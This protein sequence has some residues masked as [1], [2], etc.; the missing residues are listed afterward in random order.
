MGLHMIGLGLQNAFELGDGVGGLAVFGQHAPEVV[1][2]TNEV[3][4]QFEAALNSL[5]A[6]ALR[7][8]RSST[9]PRTL[10]VIAERGAA[11]TALR[12]S[13]SASASEFDCKAATAASSE[14]RALALRG[15]AGVA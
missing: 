3:W 4:I 6:S 12:A 2:R 9:T 7:P 5:R 10:C 14:L 13:R 8:E 1:S 15:S 11:E